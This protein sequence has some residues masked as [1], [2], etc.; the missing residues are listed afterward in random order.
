[1]NTQSAWIT[2]LAYSLGEK[3]PLEVLS[4]PTATPEMLAALK[5]GGLECY[6][7]H[8][9]NLQLLAK[10]SMSKTLASAKVAPEDVGAVVWTS[11]TLAQDFGGAQPFNG[12]EGFENIQLGAY[13]CMAEL[14]MQRAFPVFVGF[15]GCANAQA[16]LLL[17][18]GMLGQRMGKYVMVVTTDRVPDSQERILQPGYAVLSDGASSCLLRSE[19]HRGLQLKQVVGYS[20]NQLW[21]NQISGDVTRYMAALGVG[22]QGIGKLIA[23]RSGVPMAEYDHVLLN[24]YTLPTQGLFAGALGANPKNC[25]QT[26]VAGVSHVPTGDSLLNLSELLESDQSKSGSM[27]LSFGSGPSSWCAATLEL[28]K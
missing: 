2:D 9:P 6:R 13:K 15:S 21:D 10:D 24:N 7:A 25:W 3:V 17:G 14:G 28:I 12:K 4:E 8:V 18:A 26:Q 19:A 20:D 22:L 16:A 11:S 1:M 27:A 5:E 23:E